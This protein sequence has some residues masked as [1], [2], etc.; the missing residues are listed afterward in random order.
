MSNKKKPLLI[1][2]SGDNGDGQSELIQ[3]P[4]NDMAEAFDKQCFP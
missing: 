1:E 3:V 4:A 2:A